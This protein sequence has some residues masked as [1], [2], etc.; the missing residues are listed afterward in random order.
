MRRP[1]CER[2][3]FVAEVLDTAYS[4][5]AGGVNCTIGTAVLRSLLL[6]PTCVTSG[7]LLLIVAGVNGALPQF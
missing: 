7:T 5:P 6:Q 1:S 4:P 2:Q 3:K